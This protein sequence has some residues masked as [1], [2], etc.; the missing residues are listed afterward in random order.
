MN[1]SA[2]TGNA[3][4]G[5][6]PP[7]NGVDK[8][9]AR[10]NNARL[11]K[12]SR[13]DS[14]EEGRRA[15]GERSNSGRTFWLL[16][17]GGMVFRFIAAVYWSP[18]ESNAT[19]PARH[20]FE[21]MHP[22]STWPIY[23]LDPPIYPFW[24]RTLLEPFHFAPLA[25]HLYAALMSMLMPV[26]WYPWLRM[27]FQ[28]NR[29][30]LP[31]LAIFVLFPSF[32]GI[33][34]FFQPETLALPLLGLALWS[35]GACRRRP[36]YGRV[37]LAGLLWGLAFTTKITILAFALTAFA[38]FLHGIRADVSRMKLV[39]LA[40]LPILAATAIYSTV[41]L[42]IYRGLHIIEFAPGMYHFNK[43]HYESGD[44]ALIMTAK[45]FPNNSVQ[46]A[47]NSPSLFKSRGKV[48]EPFRDFK[49]PRKPC[50]ALAV[51]MRHQPYSLSFPVSYRDRIIWTLENAFYF[52]F[53]SPW[54]ENSRGG[55]LFDLEVLLCWLW[56]PLTVIT[57][58]WAIK[59]RVVTFPVLL[60]A[61]SGMFLLFQQSSIMEGRF[62]KP[63]EC[64]ALVAF[65]DALRARNQGQIS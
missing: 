15:K 12:E 31:A 8:K 33:Y 41:P 44:V 10:A 27:C 21:A 42:K 35:T 11:R 61:I 55:W 19:D 13:T 63:W 28:K 38:W 4:G 50:Q 49:S 56:L 23:V 51:D 14:L 6:E 26:C 5:L 3:E 7:A 54:P 39:L 46:F 40:L 34:S 53:G 62:R 2:E 58:F 59:Y 30:F 25:V 29:Y 18:M 20:L 16:I 32:I 36:G 57:S 37:F 47:Y 52:F 43:M 1:E 64:V 9:S 65:L 22:E 17:Y 45:Y 24:L 48:Y 60:F